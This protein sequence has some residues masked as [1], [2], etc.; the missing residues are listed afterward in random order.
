MTFLSVHEPSA[1]LRHTGW[2]WTGCVRR[3]PPRKLSRSLSPRTCSDTWPCSPSTPDWQDR[4]KRLHITTCGRNGHRFQNMQYEKDSF[5]NLRKNG[6]KPIKLTAFVFQ[7][8]LTKHRFSFVSSTILKPRYSCP[9]TLT[10]VRFTA[11]R[12]KWGC[13]CAAV[14]LASQEFQ[15]MWIMT[16]EENAQ[17]QQIQLQPLGSCPWTLKSKNIL[18]GSELNGLYC[19][20]LRWRYWEIC[21]ILLL[22]FS[23]KVPVGGYG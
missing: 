3:T 12:I 5:L 13:F 6:N 22:F 17:R 1:H 8:T 7:S 21:T 11:S 19:L 4:E 18:L 2:V 23:N 14:M 16:G 15:Q 20:T 9:P 10:T